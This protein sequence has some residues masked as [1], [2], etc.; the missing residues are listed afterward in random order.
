MSAVGC[1]L[2]SDEDAL[3][4]FGVTIFFILFGSIKARLR[5]KLLTKD[6]GF[7]FEFCHC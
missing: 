2:G 6:F 4:L 5:P 1:C 7:S 3:A